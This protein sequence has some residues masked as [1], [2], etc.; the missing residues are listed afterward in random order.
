MGDTHSLPA[1]IQISFPSPKYDITI[2]EHKKHGMVYHV[3]EHGIKDSRGDYYDA[4]V[5]LL[6]HPPSNFSKPMSKQQKKRDNE[7]FRDLS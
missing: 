3:I 1:E 2:R 5:Q 6:Y 4:D 7:W